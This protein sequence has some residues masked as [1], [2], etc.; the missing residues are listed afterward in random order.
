MGGKEKTM[1]KKCIN[2]KFYPECEDEELEFG[3]CGYFK[4]NGM[5]DNWETELA[6][7][8]RDTIHIE[9]NILDKREKEINRD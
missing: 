7:M 8:C 9:G 2:C 5:A 1:E 3:P 6:R 4:E